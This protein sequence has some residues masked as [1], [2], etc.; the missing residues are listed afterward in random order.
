VTYDSPSGGPAPFTRDRL[1]FL[2]Y[3]MAIAFGFM[4]AALGPAMPSLRADLGIS[5]FTALAAGSV[6]SGFV[7][8]R[9]IRRW[10]R[11]RVF[12]MGGTGMAAGF[13]LI[14][15]GWHPA[16]TLVGCLLAG[17][18][19]SSMLTV[20]QAT[21]SDHHP[22]HRSV[23]L[24]EV[25]TAASLGS[26]IPA[27]L[28]GA[29]L[30]MGVGWRPGFLL[31]LLILAGHGLVWG[32]EPF[33]TGTSAT[34]IKGRRLPGA[35]WL[36]WAALIP[37]VGAEWSFGAWGAEYL[38]EVAHTA[39]G[40]ASFLM[41]AFFGAMVAGRFLGARVA[42]LLNPL[43]LLLVSTAVAMGG[44]LVFWIG[45]PLALVV[46]GLLVAGLGISM[47]FPMLMSLALEMAPGRSDV[48][49]AR[50]SISSGGAVLSAPLTLGAI[51]D[52]TGI[53]TAFGL[54]PALFVLAVLLAMLSRRPDVAG[55]R[56]S[57]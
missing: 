35:Y 9:L 34:P 1:T 36:V 31:P 27:L 38:V 22:S 20:S 23:A 53:H 17:I 14:A 30:A 52:R 48:A 51:A 28:I 13:L 29:T 2:I 4:A 26:V 24:T 11:K 18:S 19:G 49:A 41:T 25:N 3:G 55:A 32:G 57:P 56:L 7:V 10:Q 12:W 40:T 6:L 37:S 39:D 45:Q 21:L 16:V 44:F 47:Q 50:V 15:V 33:P 43:P 5:H 8:A 42:R 54:V 46:V